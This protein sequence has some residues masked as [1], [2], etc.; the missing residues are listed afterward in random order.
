MG[1]LSKHLKVLLERSNLRRT[2]AA[3]IQEAK[4]H[5]IIDGTTKAANQ[6]VADEKLCNIQPSLDIII[7]LKYGDLSAL[8]KI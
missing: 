2:I 8:S 5:K 1:W 4:S 6:V 7:T 3:A